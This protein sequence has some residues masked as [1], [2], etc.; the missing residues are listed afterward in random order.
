MAK[1]TR[2]DLINETL[3]V[4]GVLQAGQLVP[5]EDA[6]KVDAKINGVV[7]SL[8]ARRVY[9]V[10]NPNSI[11][12]EVFLPL[13]RC[14]AVASVSGFGISQIDGKD[15]EAVKQLA[16]TELRLLHPGVHVNESMRVNY[17]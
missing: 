17:F 9:F 7:A 15:P 12:E 11:D 6:A 8:R 13:A 3:D 10:Q 1:R 14:V 4:L 16:E 5:P 2:N